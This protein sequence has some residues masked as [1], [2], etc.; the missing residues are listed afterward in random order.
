MRVAY[1]DCIA[2]ISGDMALAA[3][4]DAGAE[5][6]AIREH[7]GSLPLEPFDLAVEE[8]DAA[9]IRALRVTVRTGAG[10]VIRTY[11]SIRAMLDAAPLPPEARRLAQRI[12]RRLAEAEATV[13]R[14]EIDL[15]T[16]HEVGAVDS[17]VDIVGTALA[18]TALGIERSYASPVPTG[19]G[20]TRTEHGAM[21]IPGPAV[22]E[23]LRG[24]PLY[25]RGVPVELV[26]PTGAA[27]LASLVEGYGE[28]P[29]MRIGS[30]GY[31]AGSHALDFPNVIRVLVGEEDPT[32]AGAVPAPEPTGE[33]VLETNVDDLSP[34]LAGYVVDRLL[35]AGAQDAWLTP[36]V[37]KKGRPAVTISVLCSPQRA[38]ALS[39]LLFLETGTLGVRTT[40]VRK[41][42]LER[43]VIEVATSRGP[44]RVK[45][46]FLDGRPA[47]VAPE[48]DDCARIARET[49]APAREIYEEAVRLARER[50]GP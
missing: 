49:G 37:M 21:P 42:A 26:T 23:L 32:A 27:I 24:A 17:I 31:G 35:A 11:A 33:L 41:R 8:V 19:L 4:I 22:L 48:H 20:M 29:L 15:V 47:G 9:G 45:V 10:G 16:F 38:E 13:H 39:R 7:L 1:F 25:S 18:L 34:E 5:P 44:V 43:E 40:H 50:L 14:K 28:V 12:F 3:L 2:G 30:V 36:I 6:D 46:G